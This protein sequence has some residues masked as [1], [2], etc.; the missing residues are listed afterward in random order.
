ESH[1]VD[2]KSYADAARFSL[3]NWL[4]YYAH[5]YVSQFATLKP[6]VDA[7][8]ALFDWLASVVE[9]YIP[10][11]EWLSFPV[12]PVNSTTTAIPYNSTTYT[13]MVDGRWSYDEEAYR[14]TALDDIEPNCDFVSGVLRIM[15]KV[16]LGLDAANE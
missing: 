15:E 7:I 11:S 2:T 9:P 8:F 12:T 16:E 3:L 10:L 6:F 1:V 5:S 13:R 14:L 4:R